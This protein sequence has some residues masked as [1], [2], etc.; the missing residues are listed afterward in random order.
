MKNLH[1]EFDS[2]FVETKEDGDVPGP[3]MEYW[4]IQNRSAV[5]FGL[6]DFVAKWKAREATSAA[7]KEAKDAIE[8]VAKVFERKFE[9]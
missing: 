9:V 4:L 6:K 3:N 8:A 1:D 2:N 5:Y 7:L